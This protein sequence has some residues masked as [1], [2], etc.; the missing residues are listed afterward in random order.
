MLDSREYRRFLGFMIPHLNEAEK[1]QIESFTNKSGNGKVNFREFKEVFEELKL[2]ARI[3]DVVKDI[4]EL[5][6]D[7]D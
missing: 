5:C 2:I 6:F 1:K 7:S 3:K 4:N